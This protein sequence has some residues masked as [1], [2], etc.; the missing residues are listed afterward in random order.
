VITLL[1]HFAEASSEGG[2]LAA[3]GLDVRAFLFQL[4][5]FTLLLLI[6]RKWAFPVLVKTLEDRRLTV[7]KSIDQA[8]ETE[9]A[10]QN[11][12]KKIE[13]MLVEARDEAAE[14][15]TAGHREATKMVEDA[16]TKAA[17]RA[18]HIVEEAR[19][20]MEHEL[21]KARQALKQE[22]AEL[23]AEATGVI[24]QEKVDAKKNAELISKALTGAGK[25][26]KA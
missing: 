22:T 16:E 20:S 19:A 13:K 8:K 10:L 3:L 5:T 7:E 21:N 2:G 9:A 15:V 11:A 18:E 12:E 6:L 24:L 17:K 25:D 26:K 14:L 23:V 1:T 4:I